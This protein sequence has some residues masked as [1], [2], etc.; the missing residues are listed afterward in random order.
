[1]NQ[2]DADKYFLYRR[3]DGGI[4]VTTLQLD[5]SFGTGTPELLQ[6][7]EKHIVEFRCKPRQLIETGGHVIFNGS[8]I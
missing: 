5:D 8:E 7:E 2:A 4:S 1:M 3:E 6:D